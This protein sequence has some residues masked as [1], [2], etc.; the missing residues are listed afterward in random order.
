MWK[1]I[2]I[3]PIIKEDPLTKDIPIYHDYICNNYTIIM[4]KSHLLFGSASSINI[5]SKPRSTFQALLQAIL[6]MDMERYELSLLGAGGNSRRSSQAT[7]DPN[8][9]KVGSSVLLIHL[10]HPNVSRHWG[11]MFSLIYQCHRHRFRWY[12]VTNISHDLIFHCSGQTV[13]G[14]LGRNIPF[15]DV[16]LWLGRVRNNIRVVYV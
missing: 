16:E 3:S 9:W 13:N 5:K 8:E 4:P 15:F 11:I 14:D 1:I 10:I 6:D 7:L 2:F 12:G